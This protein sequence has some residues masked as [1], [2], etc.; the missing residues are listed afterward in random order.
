MTNHTDALK[1]IKQ[2][3]EEGFT[4]AMKGLLLGRPEQVLLAYAGTLDE[5]R[6]VVDEALASED[7]G[8]DKDAPKESP[9][10]DDAP[11]DIFSS[12]GLE[13]ILPLLQGLGNTLRGDTSIKDDSEQAKPKATPSDPLSDILNG[14]FGGK[15]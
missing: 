3:D 5:I 7:T 10:K 13:N 14:L 6:V 2:I 8:E 4:R 11:E 15:A 1:Q 12:L 9:E